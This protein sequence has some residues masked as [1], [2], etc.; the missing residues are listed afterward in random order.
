MRSILGK[1]DAFGIVVI[2]F[3]A[4]LLLSPNT[5]LGEE[6]IGESINVGGIFDISGP[7]N[8]I[9]APFAD[10][11]VA[12][13]EYLKK[14]QGNIKGIA[15]NLLTIDYQYNPQKSMAALSRLTTKENILG[16]LAW[17]SVDAPLIIPKAE[18]ISLAVVSAAARGRNVIGK[19]SPVVFAIAP[20]YT[21]EWV[22]ELFLVNRDVLKRK[23]F[24]PKIAI[25]YN[26]PGR[27]GSK[28]VLQRSKMLGYEVPV[29]EFLSSKSMSAS[30]I[31]SRAKEA[32]CQYVMSLTTLGPLTVLMK[33]AQRIDYHPIFFGDFFCAS[34]L[35]FELCAGAPQKT[36]VTSPVALMDETDNPGIK[37][38]IEFTG[39]PKLLNQFVAGWVGAMVLAEG[40]EKSNIN[41]DM[42]ISEARK[43]IVAGLESFK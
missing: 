5:V 35:L 28:P 41:P 18:E 36:F 40:I 14:T 4:L 25:V 7:T 24:D 10:G 20:T 37:K 39:N 11:A 6:K 38:I 2:C 17:G 8:Q 30:A 9:G 31:V 15:V 12:Y 13:F 1:K 16:L 22:E 42:T 21:D 33:D 27:P 26:E 23:I 34:Q 43:A 32:G 3:V 29:F 19:F